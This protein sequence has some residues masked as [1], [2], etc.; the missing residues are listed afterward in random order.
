M[1]KNLE[2]VLLINA[3]NNKDYDETK[4]ILK[5][6]SVN[7]INFIDE[8]VLLNAV[9]N[10]SHKIIVMLLKKHRF[11]TYHYV[12]PALYYCCDNNE[13]KKIKCII[14]NT[15]GHQVNYSLDEKH[16]FYSILAF[17][18]SCKF[19]ITEVFDLLLN[20]ESNDIHNKNEFPY[21]IAVKNNHL[22]IVKELTS[23]P[24][25]NPFAAKS[26]AIIVSYEQQNN[27]MI[28]YLLSLKG[29]K[30]N[31]KKDNPEMYQNIVVKR[32]VEIF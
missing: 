8:E 22:D 20:E 18:Y 15:K 7:K 28:N 13:L 11:G 29:V 5:E 14:K 23:F 30:E 9:K 12:L 16:N 6:K 1:T 10:S 2:N 32:K 25:T 17:N 27:H 26:R 24:E 31:L 21:R 4:R 3:I 19:G